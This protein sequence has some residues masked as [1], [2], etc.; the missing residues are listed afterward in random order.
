MLLSLP[1]DLLSE[2]LKFQEPKEIMSLYNEGLFKETIKHTN[3]IVDCK[4]LLS[5]KEIEWFKSKNI[6]VKL[7]EYHLIDESG[8]KYWYKNGNLH[9]DDDLPALISLN[10]TYES[11][12]KNGNLHRD[13]DLPAIIFS[14]GGKKWYKNGVLDRD[15]DLPSVISSNGSKYWYKSGVLVRSS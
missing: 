15:N 3:F 9:R 6:K 11:W 2:I 8:N 12:Y 5:E 4:V 7:F 1:Y 13:N 10:G 14:N